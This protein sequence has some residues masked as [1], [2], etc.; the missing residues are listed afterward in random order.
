MHSAFCESTKS[1]KS[2]P[3]L[4]PDSPVVR[5]VDPLKVLELPDFRGQHGESV[6]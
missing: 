3:K 4:L 2:R 1:M 5:H 6:V